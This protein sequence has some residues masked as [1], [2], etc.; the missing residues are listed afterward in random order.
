MANLTVTYTAKDQDWNR[1]ITR[2]WFCLD[3]TDYG[4][5]TEF[6]WDIFAIAEEGPDSVVLDSE[7]YP[8]TDDD[9]LSIAVRRACIVTDAM[10][11][12]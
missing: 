8:V 2:Y 9:Y 5:G 7:G 11:A 1:G 6:H 3:G 12:E 4:T 10:R